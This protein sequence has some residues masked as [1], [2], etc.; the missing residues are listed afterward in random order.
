MRRCVN[1]FCFCFVSS[2]LLNYDNNIKI[3][4]VFEPNQRSK[5]RKDR[6][7]STVW[8]SHEFD[9]NRS[10]NI[11]PCRLSKNLTAG[12]PLVLDTMYHGGV[13]VSKEQNQRV[14][15]LIIIETKPKL[16]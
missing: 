5:K 11:D 16:A 7:D 8:N 15:K 2:C 14:T 4:D 6:G 1:V 3:E 10:L 13:S 12:I 9:K